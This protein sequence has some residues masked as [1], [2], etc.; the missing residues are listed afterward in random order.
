MMSYA[1]LVVGI[2]ELFTHFA[3]DLAV[4]RERNADRNSFDAAYSI[5]VLRGA[6]VAIAI[7]ITAPLVSTLYGLPDLL[8]VLLCIAFTSFLQG[9]ENTGVLYFQKNLNFH[10]LFVLKFA[11]RLV[12]TVATIILAWLLATYWA[13]VIGVI[14]HRL[15]MI[16]LSYIMHPFRPRWNPSSALQM[17]KFSGWLAVHNFIHGLAERLP[18][19]VLARAANPASLAFFTTA[20]ELAT[21]ASTEI[22]A[23]ARTALF[24]GLAKLSDDR[25][26]VRNA[27]VNATA[28]M[29]MF[30][31]PIPIG[32]ALIAP[33]LIPLLLGDPWNPVVPMLQLLAVGGALTALGSNGYF[34]LLIQNRPHSL[35]ALSAIRLVLMTLTVFLLV[36]SQGPIGAALGMLI[37]AAICLIVDY[38]FSYFVLKIPFLMCVRSLWRPIVSTVAM[39]FSVRYVQMLI[40]EPA[41]HIAILAAL[42]LEIAVGILSYIGVIGA[43]WYASG[44]PDGAEMRAIRLARDLR[45]EIGWPTRR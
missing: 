25:S 24:P 40:G 13:L 44:R 34:L 32:V 38:T 10:Y 39:S 19:I 3:P 22:Q 45:A 28:L 29:V 21:L 30:A 9:L 5:N 20:N 27:I 42:A 37:T 43:L 36:P 17:L 8:P 35:V 2:V 12:A 15:A 18:A 6:F 11:P 14:L 33:K 31:L 23:P 1:I 16:S 7:A 4:L 41:N 26:E